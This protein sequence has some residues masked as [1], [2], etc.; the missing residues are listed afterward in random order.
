M[1]VSCRG[2]EIDLIDSEKIPI[3]GVDAGMSS[4]T[5]FQQYQAGIGLGDDRAI[6]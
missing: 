5:R 3:P 4:F 6:V 1:I 2:R